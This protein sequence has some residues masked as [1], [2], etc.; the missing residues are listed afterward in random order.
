MHEV[1]RPIFQIKP[2]RPLRLT[3]IAGKG[4]PERM[5][6]TAFAFLGLTAAVGLAL[7]AFFAQLGFPLLTPA[8]LPSEPVRE[9]AVAE[10][11]AL[12]HDPGLFAPAGTPERGTAAGGIHSEGGETAGTASG[13]A[14]PAPAPAPATTA[15]PE[16]GGVAAEPTG[17]ST[18]KP[19]PNPAST[20]EPTP[21][22]TGEPASE[23]KAAPPPARSSA[24]PEGAAPAPG[25]SSSAAAAAH[26]SDRGIEASSKSA[27]TAAVPPPVSS[28][29]P[30]AETG[31]GNGNGKALGHSK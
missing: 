8:P 19:A 21:P 14:G 13:G 30:D 4:L 23:P 7:V 10:A 29:A 12:P 16:E 24:P 25:N 9:R 17:G 20:S 2:E 1:V 26:A 18:P 5:R 15:T 27:A 6:S 11:V 22:P 31:P 3:S 28:S